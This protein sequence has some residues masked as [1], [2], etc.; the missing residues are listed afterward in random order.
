MAEAVIQITPTTTAATLIT[1]P[2]LPRYKGKQV[3]NSDL[4]EAIDRANLR[5]LEASNLVDS[6]SCQAD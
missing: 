1:R 2:P 3:D 5:I 6:I 4:L